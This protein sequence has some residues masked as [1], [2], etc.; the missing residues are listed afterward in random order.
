M[1]MSSQESNFV[2]TYEVKKI[3]YT[4]VFLKCMKFKN[5]LNILAVHLAALVFY[6]QQQI[7]FAV[8][9]PETGLYSIK[10]LSHQTESPCK[11]SK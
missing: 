4:K 1:S 9:N 7:F 8:S 2:L 6:M 10:K 11:S 5:L 3:E